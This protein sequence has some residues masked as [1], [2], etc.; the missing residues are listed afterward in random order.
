MIGAPCVLSEKVRN[1]IVFT[2]FDPIEGRKGEVAR[3]GV[4]PFHAYFWDLSPEGRRIAFGVS[5]ETRGNIR[6][7]P[8]SAQ[9]PREIAVQGWANLTSVAWAPDGNA[10]F[11]AGWSSTGSPLLRVFLDGHIQV[12][13]RDNPYI[14]NVVPYLDGRRIAFGGAKATGGNVWLIDHFR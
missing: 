11:A 9:A 2:A 12:L 1:E 13:A 10:L 14:E 5:Q 6:V 4:E 7:I 3:V 8:L